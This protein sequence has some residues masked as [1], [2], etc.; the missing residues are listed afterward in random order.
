MSKSSLEIEM[1]LSV[2]PNGMYPCRVA[3]SESEKENCQNQDQERQPEPPPPSDGFGRQVHW[4]L[5]LFLFFF[6]RPPSCL[7]KRRRRMS[8]LVVVL[9]LSLTIKSKV[10][11]ERG[12]RPG[13]DFSVLARGSS[14]GFRGRG[15]SESDMPIDVDMRRREIQVGREK[16]AVGH[17][18]KIVTM[19]LCFVFGCFLLLGKR[20]FSFDILFFLGMEK[21]AY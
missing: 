14:N 9:L 7:K 6:I 2:I 15:W 5:L 20:T 18:H 13:Q 16:V 10:F 21:K 8:E 3:G 11:P 12:G 1:G 4:V 19:C 17:H